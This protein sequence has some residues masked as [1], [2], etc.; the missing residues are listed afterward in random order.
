M[1]T[2]QL[3]SW[4]ALACGELHRTERKRIVTAHRSLN[5][6]AS[7]GGSGSAASSGGAPGASQHVE[8]GDDDDEEAEDGDEGGTSGQRQQQ[9]QPRQQ[10]EGEDEG[11]GAKRRDLERGVSESDLL[12][13]K[14]IRTSQGR[15]VTWWGNSG[16]TAARSRAPGHNCGMASA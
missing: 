12:P 10:D 11:E 6:T 16:G 4:L 3:R 14:Y 15:S 7:G 8:V 13:R 9:Q 1:R 5:Y 2:L